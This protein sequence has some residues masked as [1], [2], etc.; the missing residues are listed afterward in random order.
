MA[1]TPGQTKAAQKAKSQNPVDLIKDL[2]RKD[3]K[4][5]IQL[6]VI[7]GGLLVLIFFVF[8]PLFLKIQ[9]MRREA[10]D[11]SQQ[12]TVAKNKIKKIGELKQ[13][14]D[15]YSKEID[16]VEKRFLRIRDLDELLGDLSKLAADSEV[17]L[18]GSRP[19]SEKKQVL[20]EP[21]NKKYLSVSYELTLEGSYHQF[22]KFVNDIEQSERLLS[23]RDLSIRPATSKQ[24]EKLQCIVQVDAF[25]QVPQGV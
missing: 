2:W 9:P 21:F 11:L 4:Q 6:A 23:I 3:K 1:I 10:G 19:L 12:I 14:L 20:P 5:V 15:L 18:V 24:S 13:Q 7:A 17:V 22:G 8:L 25:A 16:A